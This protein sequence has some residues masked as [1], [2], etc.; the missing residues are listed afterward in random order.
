MTDTETPVYHERLLGAP[1]VCNNCLRIIKRERLEPSRNGLDGELESV[2]ERDRRTTIVGYGP[3]TSA[4]NIAG[5][6]CDR[7]GTESARDR[8]WNDTSADRLSKDRV[9]ELIMAAAAS[10]EEKG[11]DL[12]YPTLARHALQRRADGEHVDE[13]IGRAVE[14]AIT[15][16]LA[17][18]TRATA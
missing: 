6:F 8:I 4:S 17:G 13:A 10:L 3:A 18:E 11:V 1:D 15:A 5:V 12:H 16:E 14:A 2:Y 9:K 7:C